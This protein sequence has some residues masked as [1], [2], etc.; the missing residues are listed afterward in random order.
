MPFGHVSI[1]RIVGGSLVGQNV[2]HDAAFGEFGN[3]VSAIADQSD[4]NVFFLANGI[5]QD[6]QRFI[7]R[8]DHEVAVA[9]LQPLLDALRI[10]V[11]AE[12]CRAGHGCGE[13]LRSAHAAHAAGDDELA[14][15]VAAEMFFPGGGESFKRSLHDSLRADVD[16]A[17]R[18]SS[19]RTSSGRRV[20]VR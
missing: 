13:R 20:R 9:G 1:Q 6:A 7:E 19:G 18:R 4:R 3:N 2:G 17:S 16:P 12:E 15:E 8:G 5:L 11:N 14:C 10:D